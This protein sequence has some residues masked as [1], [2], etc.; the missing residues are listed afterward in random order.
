[1]KN[2]ELLIVVLWILCQLLL[3]LKQVNGSKNDAVMECFTTHVCEC[4]LIKDYNTCWE[5][6]PDK[7]KEITFRQSIVSKL[8]D[9]KI[10]KEFS[11][12]IDEL[13][14]Y[15]KK[16]NSNSM[17]TDE[18]LKLGVAK[19]NKSAFGNEFLMGIDNLENLG[20]NMIRIIPELIFYY[21]TFMQRYFRTLWSN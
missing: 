11:E 19:N 18:K 4:N 13:R 5:K 1:M 15:E 12:I 9:D 8:K 6:A 10:R 16:V 21:S 2:S 7:A 17:P 20:Y 14:D 3:I